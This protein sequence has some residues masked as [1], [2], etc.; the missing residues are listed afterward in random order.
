M[1]EKKLIEKGDLEIGMVL[2]ENLYNNKGSLLAKE[3]LFVDVDTMKI[4]DNLSNKKIYIVEDYKI[5]NDRV[6][7]LQGKSFFEEIDTEEKV[8]YTLNRITQYLKFSFEGLKVNKN[9]HEFIK[10][11]RS[12]VK[13]IKKNTK[14]NFSLL[15]KLVDSSEFDHYLYRHSVNVAILC[16]LIGQWMNLGKEELDKLIMAGLLHDI[17]KSC[18]KDSIINK[19]GKLDKNEF[20]EIKK[21]PFYSHEIL[22]KMKYEDKAVLDAVC[23]HHEKM[24]G[25]GYPFGLQG[26][27][28]PLYARI[29]TVADIFDAMTSDRV[30]KKKE[31][32]FRVIE[33]FQK[34]AFGKLDSKVVEVFVNKFTEYYLGTEVVLNNGKKGKIIRLNS[35]NITKPLVSIDNT[36]H[37]DTSIDTK[38]GIIGFPNE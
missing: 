7:L 19:P 6:G 37:I 38:I 27:N 4:L 10:K 8:S 36:F 20:E 14:L 31:F 35:E 5:R 24:D 15:V 23:F 30:Y 17:G 34:E 3:G 16:H 12:A 1:Y 21:H 28:I 13:D 29:L 22:K 9:S 26:E 32:P 11:I 33:M 18:I 25:S 2:G